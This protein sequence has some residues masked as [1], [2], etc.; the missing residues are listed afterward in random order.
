[1]GD[2]RERERAGEPRKQQH[3]FFDDSVCNRA[4]EE[5]PRRGER[6]EGCAE[7]RGIQNLAGEKKSPK[8]G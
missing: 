5:Q 2:E 3:A 1:M 4:N 6:A 7:E 8:K